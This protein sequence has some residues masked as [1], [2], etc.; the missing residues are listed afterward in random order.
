MNNT[1]EL[2][3]VYCRLDGMQRAADVVICTTLD[4]DSALGQMA[5]RGGALTLAGREV[6]VWPLV[7]L[8]RRQS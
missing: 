5:D 3:P 4:S 2:I 6:S 8:E 7:T 1:P